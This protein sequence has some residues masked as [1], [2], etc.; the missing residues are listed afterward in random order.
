MGEA[1]ISHQLGSLE[2]ITEHNIVVTI[3]LRMGMIRALTPLRKTKPDL[4]KNGV[5]ILPERHRYLL[6]SNNAKQGIPH[7]ALR[8]GSPTQTET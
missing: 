6:W 1:R 2:V 8:N 4:L 5:V 3:L 7:D